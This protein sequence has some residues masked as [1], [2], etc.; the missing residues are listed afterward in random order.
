MVIR[1]LYPGR[2][3]PVHWGHISVARWALE[4]VDELII[5]VGTAQESHTLSN[6]FTA[7]ERIMMIKYGLKDAG[8]DI[9]RVYIVPVPDIL[10]NAAW[11]SYVNMYVPPYRYAVARNPLVV[12]LFKEAGYEVLIPPP[13]DRE[14]YSS[15]KIRLMMVRGSDEWRKL[16]PP[17]VAKIIDEFRGVERIREIS[18]RD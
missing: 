3:Q 7:G 12:R 18:G 8:I 11:V 5:V 16:V 6:P 17:S 4:R 14:V 13:Y 9:T 1:A 2:F 10:M 15:T